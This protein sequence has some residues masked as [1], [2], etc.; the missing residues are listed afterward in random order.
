MYAHICSR[1]YKCIRPSIMNCGRRGYLAT[2]RGLATPILCSYILICAWR[3]QRCLTAARGVAVPWLK[4]AGIQCRVP[5]GSP[6]SILLSDLP[7]C[8]GLLTALTHICTHASA[9][10]DSKSTYPQIYKCIQYAM[11]AAGLPGN[12]QRPHCST[13]MWFYTRICAWRSPR[14]LAAARGVAFPCLDHVSIQ[15]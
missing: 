6:A 7:A 14:Y 3:W 10:V 15:C 13:Y 5:S 11:W 9:F 1:I 2:A 4:H 8:N 12:S